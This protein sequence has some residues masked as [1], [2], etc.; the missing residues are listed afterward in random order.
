MLSEF[1]HSYEPYKNRMGEIYT[2]LLTEESHDGLHWVGHNKY[3]EQVYLHNV[4]Q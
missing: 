2:I 3:Y 4:V 1:S